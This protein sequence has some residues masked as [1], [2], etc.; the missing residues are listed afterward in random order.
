MNVLILTMALFCQTGLDP[1]PGTHWP[2]GFAPNVASRMRLYDIQ[3]TDRFAASIGWPHK[4]FGLH[5]DALDRDGRRELLNQQVAWAKE[6]GNPPLPGA[7]RLRPDQVP[8]YVRRHPEMTRGARPIPFN[9]WSRTER[10]GFGGGMTVMEAIRNGQRIR[11]E[12]ERAA[13]VAK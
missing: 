4:L 5:Y 7:I 12:R 3:M 9:V 11:R 10:G 2:A 13:R 1:Q 8:A 6:W